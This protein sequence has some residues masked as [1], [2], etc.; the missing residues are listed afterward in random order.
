MAKSKL[1]YYLSIFI[2][3]IFAAKYEGTNAHNHNYKHRF[4]PKKL[5]VFGD[6]YVDTGNTNKSLSTSWNV[7][8][9]V[10]FPNKPAGRFSDGRVLTDF[11]ARF[12]GLKSPVPYMLRN[13]AGKRAVSYGTNFAFGG[14]GVFDTLFPGANMTVQIGFLRALLDGS[15]YSKRDVDTSMALVALSGN[16]Y[17]TYLFR[18]GLFQNISAYI[19]QVVNQLA[20]NLRSIHHMGVRKVFVTSLQPLGCL[21]KVTIL[22]SF[23]QCNATL[24]SAVKIHN[25]LLRQAV[26]KLNN[27]TANTNG[28]SPAFIIL[29]LFSSFNTTIF[30]DDKFVNPLKP[31]CMG[32]KDGSC[33]TVNS[34]GEKMYTVCEKPQNSIFWDTVHP[35]QAGWRAVYLTLQS[36]LSQI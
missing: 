28:G 7:P 18:G 9:G 23:S 17:S 30:R 5:F 36:S 32:I 35:T 4:H 19:T 14:T 2:F 6:S 33:G 13:L 29:D 24:N 25:L 34:S 21:P 22:N 1:V 3:T 8:Y 10:T 11:L 15:H 31:C 20:I 26:A 12:Y 16:D 27:E